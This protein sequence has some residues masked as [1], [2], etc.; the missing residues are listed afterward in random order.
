MLS[1][2]PWCLSVRVS[3]RSSPTLS[4]S[5]SFLLSSFWLMRLHW[6]LLPWK[7]IYDSLPVR[8][9]WKISRWERIINFAPSLQV[10]SPCFLA[11]PPTSWWIYCISPLCQVSSSDSSL[12]A[13]QSPT[14]EAHTDHIA[15]YPIELQLSPL[16]WD[17]SSLEAFVEVKCLSTGQSQKVP[18]R[19]Q[20]IG[21][22]DDPRNGQSSYECT[23][24]PLVSPLRFYFSASRWMA[25]ADGRSG[26]ELPQH[27]LDTWT[28]PCHYLL[29][30]CWWARHHLPFPYSLPRDSLLVFSTAYHAWLA[31]RYRGP[32]SGDQSAFLNPRGSPFAQSPTNVPA[33]PWT[34]PYDRSLSPAKLWSTGSPYD[35]SG[36]YRRTSPLHRSGHLW[37]LSLCLSL[38]MS[39]LGLSVWTVWSFCLCVLLRTSDWIPR[40]VCINVLSEYVFGKYCHFMALT[41][42]SCSS[43]DP[44]AQDFCPHPC[45]KS[46][47]GWMTTEYLQLWAWLHSLC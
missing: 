22:K 41:F 35:D 43:Q 44:L 20:L 42:S 3:L 38:R 13:I 46:L 1:S 8:P 29:L 28:H 45:A 4:L 36:L 31:P 10:F 18:V 2:E 19:I 25:A 14:F 32:A 47:N 23:Q 21:S 9:S 34:S 40:L 16:L 27:Y 6:A 30:F 12:I 39:V 5:P 7:P 17:R 11:P 15:Q 33:S 26:R 37:S 24:K